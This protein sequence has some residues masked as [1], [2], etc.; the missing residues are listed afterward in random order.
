MGKGTRSLP[1]MLTDRYELGQLLGEGKFA[2]VYHGTHRATGEE[3]AVKVMEQEKLAKLGATEHVTRE[4]TAMQRLRHPNVVR[5]HEVMATRTRVYVVMEYARGGELLRYFCRGGSPGPAGFG[6]HEARRL[7]QQLV[8]ALAYCH[9]RGVFHRD[10]KPDNLL[11][12]EKWDLKVADF[13]LSALPDTERREG[14]LQTVCGTPMYIAPEVF[15]RR[16]YDGAK[17]DVWAC[18]VVLYVL[19]TGRRPFPDYNVTQLYRMINQF[20]FHC[21]AS[22][23]IDLVRLFRRLLHP[24]PERRISIPEI[25]ETRWFRKGGFKEVTYYVDS[26]DRLR[27]L[28]SVDD[29]PDL[30]DS[31]DDTLFGS[32]SSSS[33]L[34]STPVAG[35]PRGSGVGIH[36]SVSA[37]ALSEL[38]SMVDD[39]II[40]N[41]SSLPPRPVMPRPKSLNAFDII[42]S[43]PSFDLSGLFE[44][45][46][47]KMRFIS[48][49][50]VPEIIAKLKEIAGMV[51]FTARS[52]DCQVSIEAT[53]NGQ[54]GALAISAK[55][56]ELTPELVMVQ[57][58]KKAGDT[59]E[60]SRF[61]DNELKTGL[62]DLVVDSQ[63]V[64]DSGDGSSAE[65][66]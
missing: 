8:S 30:Y 41:A 6:E 16:G 47:E 62:R 33:P 45:R 18:G 52:K 4:I 15:S 43:S 14:Y 9:A 44:E 17:A 20:K 49:A 46:G 13:G 10:I 66:E 58:C 40:H 42:A 34:S 2:K 57:V 27:S 60:Y 28:D 1:A 63:P 37:P 12:D 25:M 5:I 36:T 26:N 24:N 31:D 64:T 32:S 38:G 56:F 53:R 3:V 51:S 50:P 54:K 61:C 7:F 29:E 65:A 19:V 22:F 23:S 21:P 59:V 39:S 48:G 55:V 11:L 35:T